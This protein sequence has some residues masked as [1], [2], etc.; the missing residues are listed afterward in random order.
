MTEWLIQ[1]L[2]NGS[3]VG[4]D[5]KLIGTDEWKKWDKKLSDA[6]I[7]LRAE[8]TNLVDL[9]WPEGERPPHSTDPIF[10]HELQFAGKKWE[11]KVEEAREE[12]ENKEA[13]MMVL[14]AL[15]E[16]AW[17]LNLRG[18]DIP[19][20][21]VFR[22]YVF[23]GR[24][25]VELFI[26]KGKITP[27]VD[28]HLNVNQCGEEECVTISEYSTVLTRLQA[29]QLDHGIRKVL[30]PSKY[31]Y[32]GGVSYAIYSAVPEDKRLFVTSPVL[33]M[34]AR[35]NEVEVQGMKRAHI[36]DAVALCDFLSF[37]EQEI[38]DGNA[39]NEMEAAETLSEYREQQDHYVGLSFGTT[40]AF[41]PNG[42]VI[43]YKPRNETNRYIT[44]ES[45]YLL[46]SGGQYKDGTTDVTRTMHYGTPTPFQVEAYTRVLMGAIDLATLVF[47]ESTGDKDV[48]IM[49]RKHL[50]EV[51]LDYRHGTGHGIGMFL[52]VHE[53]PTQVRIYS[54]E[55]HKF[56]IGQFFSDGKYYLD[57]QLK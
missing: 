24:N 9:V 15:D 21:P 5:P 37:M 23:I 22:S 2:S 44:T 41:G 38:T 55:E 48:D 42:A 4:A 47:P 29:L 3:V 7:T 36:K 35:K 11:K 53:A 31:S 45:L 49:A 25:S 19:N 20:T 56:E 27:A 39:W 52:S 13:D 8:E 14:T 16:I 28:N 57:S 33:F 6:N 17:L 32:S 50:Y 30:L 10:I 12:M 40:S 46:D 54:K 43:H 1:N 26:P 34:K 18:N 51:G